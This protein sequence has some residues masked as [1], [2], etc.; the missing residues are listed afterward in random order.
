LFTTL[1]VA[2]PTLRITQ[3]S[4]W[5]WIVVGLIQSQSVHLSQLA[6]YLPSEAKA[7]GRIAQV[8]RWLANPRVDVTVL[9]EPL[10]QAVL[11]AW[12]G[13]PVFIILDGC[14]VNHAQLQ[15]FRLSLSHCFR[16]LPLAWLVLKGKGLIHMEACAPLLA[17]TG[18]RHIFSGSRL[19]RHRLGGKMLEIRLELLDSRGK[20]HLCRIARWT[21]CAAC[22][23]RRHARTG[24]LFQKRSPYARQAVC[25]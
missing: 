7:A 6:L 22:P 21:L 25:L 5:I 3:L 19:S 17:H 1:R 24:A 23:T 15:F 11:D 4:N 18:Q 14:L 9:Y 13:K 12:A 10:I 16:A 20:Q 2:H 8:R